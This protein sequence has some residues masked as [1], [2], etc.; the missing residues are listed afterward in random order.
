VEG[1][2]RITKPLI[3]VVVVAVDIGTEQ[4]RNASR[5][6]YLLS[7]MVQNTLNTFLSKCNLSERY[8]SDR[9]ASTFG[10]KEFTG[11]VMAVYLVLPSFVIMSFV[12][13]L[14]WGNYLFGDARLFI[15]PFF[16][17]CFRIDFH[18]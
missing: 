9:C 1:L 7:Q 3:H 6:N 8:V 16:Q 5:M 12:Q 18:S 2:R 15:L 10:I 11:L 13:P 14:L 4:F 17:R